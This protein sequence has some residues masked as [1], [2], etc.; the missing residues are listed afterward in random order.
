M[1]AVARSEQ[2]Q[3]LSERMKATH[4]LLQ[5]DVAALELDVPSHP[6]DGEWS[7]GEVLA[8]VPEFLRYWSGEVERLREQPGAGFGRSKQDAGRVGWVA[9][10]GALPVRALI[11]DLNRAVDDAVDTVASLTDADLQQAGV[12]FHRGRMTVLDVVVTFL[13]EHLEEHQLQLR[14]V[15]EDGDRQVMHRG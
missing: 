12:H 6:R 3:V 15:V 9:D 4:L 2:A 1:S 10:R 13:V 5:Q 11:E 14:T 7:A 8:H